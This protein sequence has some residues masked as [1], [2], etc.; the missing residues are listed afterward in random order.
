MRREEDMMYMAYYNKN[1]W[2]VN[3][4]TTTGPESR[5]SIVDDL[6][7]GKTVFEDCSETWLQQNVP[8]FRQA[9]GG[10]GYSTAEE[11]FR[12][13]Q[14]HLVSIGYPR[15]YIQRHA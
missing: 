8:V 2:P 7:P 5:L 9:D 3:G 11:A 6:A 13:G 10:Y 12:A 15:D 14:D 4:N 1:H